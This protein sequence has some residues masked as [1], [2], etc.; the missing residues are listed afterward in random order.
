MASESA[1][2]QNLET[3]IA[4]GRAMK[5]LLVSTNSHGKHDKKIKGLDWKIYKAQK[6]LAQID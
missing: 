3:Y 2:K 4:Q 1:R 6:S 5:K